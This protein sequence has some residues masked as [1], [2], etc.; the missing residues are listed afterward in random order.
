MIQKQRQQQQQKKKA[1]NKIHSK[2]ENNTDT[3]LIDS[4]C[5]RKNTWIKC[6]KKNRISSGLRQQCARDSIV[7]RVFVFLFYFFLSYSLHCLS[8]CLCVV[9]DSVCVWICTWKTCVWHLCMRR[10]LN[11]RETF[12][13][14]I[15]NSEGDGRNP[16]CYCCCTHHQLSTT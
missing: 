15:L 14:V 3:E 10:N 2:R 12:T 16:F 4:S 5:E 8:M 11:S 7:H 1:C 9:K 13:K 6:E